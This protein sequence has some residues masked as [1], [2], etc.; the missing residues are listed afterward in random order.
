M[1]AARC[2]QL[3][4]GAGSRRGQR[5]FGLAVAG[6]ALAWLAALALIGPL[7]VEHEIHASQA[8]VSDGD[9]TGATDHA[10][11]AR[12]IEPWAASPY[13]QLGLVAERAGEYPRAAEMLGK[14][15]ERED[16][17]WEL[18]D[19]RSRVEGEAGRPAAAQAR[20]RTTRSSSTRSTAPAAG[21]RRRMTPAGEDDAPPAAPAPP[22]RRA[23]DAAARRRRRRG[24]TSPRRC[25]SAARCCGACSRPATGLVLVAAL[26]VATAATSSAD[27]ATLFWAVLFSPILILV[28]KL[29]G[30]YDHDHRRI[31]HSTLDELPALVSASALGVLALDGLLALTPA[32]AL[33]PSTA[34]GVGVGVLGGSFALRGGDPLR[35]APGRRRRHRAGRSARRWPPTRSRGGSRP[36]PEARLEI[37]GY[38]SAS[39]RAPAPAGCRGSA[40]SPSSSRIAAEQGI[41]RVIVTEEEMGEAAAER[42]IEECKAAGLGLTFLPR[43]HGLLGP[44][45]RAQPPRRAAGPRLPLLRPLALDA[46]DEARHG[47]RRLGAAAGPAGAALRRDRAPH[48]A[49]LGPAGPL[50][51][52]S[53]RQG[54]ASRSWCSSSARWSPTP[55]SGS[56]TSASTSRR[57]RS[58]PSR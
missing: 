36:I 43:H 18:Y 14:A 4:A 27:V 24:A 39:R 54:R 53:R 13:L 35:L 17:N 58:R 48:P 41:E 51:P 1:A 19:L 37:V 16:R 9:L 33:A 46:G 57:S 26:C 22:P 8:A 45:D 44:R 50:P 15:I 55:R 34:I 28:F 49:R 21:R 11:T 12:S 3:P 32:G 6:L 56:A 25:S 30:L 23:G 29:Q 2:E 7:L 31:R 5:G 42:L 20:P 38:V 10:E 40:T 47:R 52:A